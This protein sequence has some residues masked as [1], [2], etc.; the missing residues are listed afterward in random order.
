VFHSIVGGNEQ[1]GLFGIAEI[2]ADVFVVV[3]SS[4]SPGA[5]VGPNTFPFTTPVCPAANSA[6]GVAV[7]FNAGTIGPVTGALELRVAQHLSSQLGGSTVARDV[8]AVPRWSV[9][10]PGLLDQILIV[11]STTDANL[12]SQLGVVFSGPQAMIG[13]QADGFILGALPMP[14]SGSGLPWNMSFFSGTFRG[15]PANEGLTGIQGWNE[16]LD[17]FVVVGFGSLDFSTPPDIEVGSYYIDTSTT[18]PSPFQFK[19]LKQTRLGGTGAER[20]AAMGATTASISSGLPQLIALPFDEYTLGDPAGGGVAV[21]QMA[22]V[23]VGGT[24]QSFDY[25]VSVN[26][27]GR[28]RAVFTPAPTFSRNDAVRTVVDLLPAEVRRTDGTG[29]QFSGTA[30]YPLPGFFGG[31]TPEC[32]L[33]PFGRRIGDPDPA[34]PRML[35]DCEERQPPLPGGIVELLV[36]RPPDGAGVVASAWQFDVLGTTLFPFTMV[37]EGVLLWTTNNPVTSWQAGA[38]GRTLRFPVG[39][40]PASPGIITAQLFC[41]LTTPVSGGVGP[42]CTGQSFFAASPALW[43]TY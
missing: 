24:T 14:P 8:Y 32:V 23:N 9:V 12:L 15:G 16:F 4:G 37:P 20:P 30:Q 11:G 22:R 17:H 7:V 2:D 40:L 35:I 21:D 43:F 41:V 6:H 31:T 18:A 13:G 5:V 38:P 27:L 28:S 33:S 3:G 1:D 10:L 42:V 39:A 19:R 25:P 29:D 36:I 26:P 34:L